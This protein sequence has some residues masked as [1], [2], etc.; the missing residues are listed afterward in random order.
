MNSRR[1]LISIGVIRKPY[2]DMAVGG[3]VKCQYDY[4][5]DDRPQRERVHVVY[6]W[7]LNTFLE[8]KNH[9]LKYGNV[10]IG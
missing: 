3:V 6:E 5:S 7:P 9:I 2:V 4:L 8:L 1:T 10:D